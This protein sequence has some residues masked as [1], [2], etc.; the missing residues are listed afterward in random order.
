MMTFLR[1]K[2]IKIALILLTLLALTTFIGKGHSPSPRYSLYAE[3]DFD[4][5]QFQRHPDLGRQLYLV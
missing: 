2:T 4:P 1:S 3:S 5:V